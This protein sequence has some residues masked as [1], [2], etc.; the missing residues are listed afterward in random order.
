MKA[1]A[2]NLSLGGRADERGP[3]SRGFS[4]PVTQ[5][6][7]VAEG[8][9]AAQLP[10]FSSARA[11]NSANFGSFP[12]VSRVSRLSMQPIAARRAGNP[13]PWQ[14]QPDICRLRSPRRLIKTRQGLA[15]L[16]AA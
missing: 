14:V 6:T 5:S 13:S 4:V 3:R 10:R 9:A 15:R 8:V 1:S 11:N 7:E 12:A 16:L 2:L